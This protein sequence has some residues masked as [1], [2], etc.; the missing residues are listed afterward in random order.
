[1]SSEKSG[2]DWAKSVAG[3]CRAGRWRGRN[4]TGRLGPGRAGRPAPL[5]QSSRR[6]GPRISQ[7]LPFPAEFGK[8]RV[9]LVRYCGLH[10]QG[11]PSIHPRTPLCE[12]APPG[13]AARRGSPPTD[14]RWAGS[15]G[16]RGRRF[17]V[18]PHSKCKPHPGLQRLSVKTKA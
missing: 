2:H 11:S 3:G 6:L 13:P 18:T 7:C 12:G 9:L 10:C 17:A 5:V 4:K 1:M 16:A 14:W 8:L 15:A